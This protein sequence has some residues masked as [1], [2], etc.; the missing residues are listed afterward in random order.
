MFKLSQF[1]SEI[2]S[3]GV[4]RTNTFHVSFAAPPAIRGG[5]TSRL[6][7]NSASDVP[8]D[9]MSLRCESVQLPGMGFA[10][11]DGPP[12]MGYGPIEAIP[13]GAVFDDITCTFLVDARGDVHRFFYRWMN[14]IVNFH[15]RGQ[16]GFDVSGRGPVTAMKPYEVNYKDNTVTDLTIDVYDTGTGVNT[17]ATGATTDRTGQRVLSAKVYRAFPKLLP[18]LDMSWNSTDEIVRLSIPFNYT[19]FEVLYFDKPTP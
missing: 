1:R 18:S 6:L 7:D 19:D 8:M 16:T 10:T 9:R 11:I 12:R 15:S 4:M 5:P 13:Y 2:E 3:R 14:S 17:A